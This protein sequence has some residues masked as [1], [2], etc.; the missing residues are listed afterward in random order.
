[1]QFALASV[2]ESIRRNPDKYNNLLFNDISASST[3][4]T[5]PSLLSY[6]E[7]YKDMILDESNRLYD[8]LL[9]HFT[10]SIYR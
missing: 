8:R 6:I 1:L 4:A 3:M 10:N 2:I 7:A 5:N 9:K